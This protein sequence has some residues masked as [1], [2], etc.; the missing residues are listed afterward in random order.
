MF[1]D[2]WYSL[3]IHLQDV[4]LQRLQPADITGCKSALTLGEEKS[5]QR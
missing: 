5:A 3:G 4:H 2:L 1:R